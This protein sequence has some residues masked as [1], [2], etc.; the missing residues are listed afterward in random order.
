LV[1][2][3]DRNNQKLQNTILAMIS[4]NTRLA[5]TE[6]TQLLIDPGT[7]DGKNSGLH[8]VSAVK[9]ENLY[10]VSQADIV[11]VIGHLPASEMANVDTCLK[12]SL[13]LP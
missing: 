13:D 1:I 12:A 2:Q 8:G 5:T 10:T 4:G 3:A 6:P 9:C 7:P 11:H